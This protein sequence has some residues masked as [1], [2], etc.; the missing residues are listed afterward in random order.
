M[1]KSGRVAA[2]SRQKSV[3]V[4]RSSMGRW[5]FL[6][7]PADFKIR[8]EGNSAADLFLSAM[9]ALAEILRPDSCRDQHQTEIKQKIEVRAND[10]TSLLVDFLNKVLFYSQVEGV[11]FCQ[12]EIDKLTGNYLAATIGGS[13]TGEFA[14]DIKAATYHQA[15]VK[16]DKS[17][18]YSSIIIFDI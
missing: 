1:I 2:S 15:E 6:A 17:G 7:H 12:L 10:L 5:Q 18:K 9:L 4:A 13:K 8:V 11:V 16:K 3:N 14:I